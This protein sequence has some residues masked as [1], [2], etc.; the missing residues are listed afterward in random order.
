MC[1]CIYICIICMCV[2][3]YIR[4][5]KSEGKREGREGRRKKEGRGNW[6]VMAVRDQV[7]LPSEWSSSNRQWVINQNTHH[8]RANSRM[9]DPVYIILF[10]F[11]DAD[12]Q[13]CSCFSRGKPHKQS[14]MRN[15]GRSP[16]TNS[17]S[18]FLVDS[19]ISLYLMD[20]SEFPQ[21]RSFSISSCCTPSI[22]LSGSS[23]FCL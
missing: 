16:F 11:E 2:Y 4:A 18:R 17:H 1:V 23:Q 3:E 13:R 20:H 7:Y 8:V 21:F 9:I 12:F 15:T 10:A 5:R 19:L 22:L 14:K 6:W